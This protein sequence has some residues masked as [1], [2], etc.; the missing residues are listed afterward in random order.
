M[1]GQTNK[2]TSKKE[3]QVFLSVLVIKKYPIIFL[4]LVKR[5]VTKKGKKERKSRKAENNREKQEQN[6]DE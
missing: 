2:R 1:E 5:L 4:V 3:I 6:F